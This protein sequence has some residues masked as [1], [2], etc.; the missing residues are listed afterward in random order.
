[1][2]GYFYLYME[3]FAG[4]SVF[5]KYI[6]NFMELRTINFRWKRVYRVQQGIQWLRGIV[7]DG[8]CYNV[9]ALFE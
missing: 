6:S 7:P 1:M 5:I 4:I 2:L 8:F 9:Q 3:R